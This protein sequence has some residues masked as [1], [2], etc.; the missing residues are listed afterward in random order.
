MHCGWSFCSL[1][2][3]IACD[4]PDTTCDGQ[5]GITRL[6]SSRIETE[7]GGH[8]HSEYVKLTGEHMQL[9]CTQRQPLEKWLA[10][11]MTVMMMVVLT[12]PN[13]MEDSEFKTAVQKQ[14]TDLWQW[15]SKRKVRRTLPAFFNLGLQLGTNR[16]ERLKDVIKFTEETHFQVDELQKGRSRLEFAAKSLEQTSTNFGSLLEIE[17]AITSKYHWSKDWITD[18]MQVF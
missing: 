3:L 4:L 13:S 2:L 5:E 8:N 11:S 1:L 7:G 18:E 15:S 16:S 12:A 14:T 17:E 10:R 6:V 9:V